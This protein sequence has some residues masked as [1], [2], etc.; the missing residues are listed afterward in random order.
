MSLPFDG[1]KVVNTW[2]LEKKWPTF[3]DDISK[4]IF[5]NENVRIVNMISL[6]IIPKGP[7][8]NNT[9]L[10]QLMA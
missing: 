9:A 1:L 2:G 3:S 5:P 8:D 4:C 6:K 7:V 10:V